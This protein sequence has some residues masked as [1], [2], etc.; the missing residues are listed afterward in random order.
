MI[1]SGVHDMHTAY[2]AGVLVQIRDVDPDVRDRLKQRAAEEGLSLNAYVK[3]VLEE[4]AAIPS[5][6]EVIRR[7]RERGNLLPSTN[8]SD[9]VE[10]IRESREERDRELMSR[11]ERPPADEAQ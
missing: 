6:S 7:L 4:A 2:M 11:V 3:K 10:L 1:A 9:T 8:V 5:R